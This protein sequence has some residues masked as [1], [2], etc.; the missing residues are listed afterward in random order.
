MHDVPKAVLRKAVRGPEAPSVNDEDKKAN[1]STYAPSPLT[2]SLIHPFHSLS[3]N[4]THLISSAM[5]GIVMVV[6]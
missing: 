5:V 6:I 4:S 2:K 3:L 1:N